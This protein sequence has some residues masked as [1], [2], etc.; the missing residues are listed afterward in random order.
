M[1]SPVKASKAGLRRPKIQ[2]KYKLTLKRAN[3]NY[4][5]GFKQKEKSGDAKGARR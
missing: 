2:P 1:R 5:K 4:K 3:K